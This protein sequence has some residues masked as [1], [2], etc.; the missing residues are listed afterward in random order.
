M[1]VVGKER[2]KEVVSG[3]RWN[4]P[5]MDGPTF[6]DVKLGVHIATKQLQKEG[7]RA[8]RG[9]AVKRGKDRETPPPDELLSLPAIVWSSFPYGSVH[10]PPPPKR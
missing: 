9:G 10:K 3:E 6:G 5:L 8:E 2:T 7:E 4:A 1:H